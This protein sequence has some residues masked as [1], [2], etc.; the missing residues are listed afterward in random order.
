MDKPDVPIRFDTDTRQLADQDLD[1]LEGA[2]AGLTALDPPSRK[3]LYKMGPK[4]EAFSR[5]TFHLLVQNPQVV[6]GSLGL[7]AA[8]ADLDTLDQLRPRLARVRQLLERL[9]DS[10]MVLGAQVDAAARE[11]YGL[12]KVSG[13]KQGLEALRQ[14]LGTRFRPRKRRSVATGQDGQAA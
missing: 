8:L 3:R 14:Q 10:S 6:T 7:D 11:G 1:A 13:R 2:F 5:Q 9:S 12:L 4:A